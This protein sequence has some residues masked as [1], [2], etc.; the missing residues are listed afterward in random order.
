M[1]LPEYLTPTIIA[2][3]ATLASGLASALLAAKQARMKRLDRAEADKIIEA[4]KS[5][6]SARRSS[7]LDTLLQR[8]PESGDSSPQILSRL[9]ELITKLPLQETRAGEAHAV[10]SLISGYHEQALSQAQAQFWFS[11]IA[12]T[13]G[14]G[15]ILYAG[16][17]IKPENLA[18]A[19]KTLPGV[20]MDAVA[21]LFFRQAT[22]TRQRATELYDRLRK[23]KQTTEAIVLVASIEDLKIR[24]SVQAQIAL[25]MSGLEPT[26]IDLTKLKDAANPTA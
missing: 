21:F 14:F 3:A 26:P 1:Y 17:D 10:E 15:W 23:D 2:A 16:M 4:V 12:A 7:A 25:H 13:I 22:E 24:S 6:D 20:V 9:E 5:E 19:L 11:V 8:M 18:S